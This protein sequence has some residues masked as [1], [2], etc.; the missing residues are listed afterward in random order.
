VNS[1]VSG[2]T[3]WI[4]AADGLPTVT[5]LTLTFGKHGSRSL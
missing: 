2:T 5:V 1:L 3:T 4:P